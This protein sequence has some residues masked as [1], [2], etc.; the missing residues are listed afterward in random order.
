MRTA[1]V[2][3]GSRATGQEFADRLF[4]SCRRETPRCYQAIR[5]LELQDR[6]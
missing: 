6:S 5:F 2:T 1:V 4:L 3:S